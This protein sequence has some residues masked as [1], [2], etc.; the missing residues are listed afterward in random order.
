M[1]YRKLLWAVLLV[2]SAVGA[3]WAVE[4][5]QATPLRS[6]L[7]FGFLLICPGLALIPLFQLT[8][9]L[10][11]AVLAV[12]LSLGL[13][14]LLATVMAYTGLWS[15]ENALLLLIGL[16]LTAVVTRLFAVVW[17]I[18]RKTSYVGYP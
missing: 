3:Q 13:E 10:V 4:T 5:N 12:G 2:A 11:A 17:R 1:T 8:D 16:T 6:G 14:T 7:L 15:P 9:G 18:V